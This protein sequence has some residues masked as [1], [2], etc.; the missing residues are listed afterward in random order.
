MLHGGIAVFLL[1]TKVSRKKIHGGTWPLILSLT[2]DTWPNIVM[3]ALELALNFEASL[4]EWCHSYIIMVA[5]VTT[6]LA[7]GVHLSV[8]H[9]GYP[10]ESSW[11]VVMATLL[12]ISI[13]IL[14]ITWLS[15]SVTAVSSTCFV[16]VT[17]R[18]TSDMTVSSH[19]SC[20][21]LTGLVV[22]ALLSIS[23]G[24]VTSQYLP[25]VGAS[26]PFVVMVTLLSISVSLVIWQPLPALAAS[27]SYVAMATLLSVSVAGETWPPLPAVAVSPAVSTGWRY[28]STRAS[29]LAAGWVGMRRRW[30]QTLRPASPWTVVVSSRCQHLHHRKQFKYFKWWSF[31]EV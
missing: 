30:E 31:S 9:F 15:L 2:R 17:L 8:C 13:A 23:I 26:L 16:R 20:M 7:V 27:L 14:I 6:L 18:D 24:V 1:G 28:S 29:S 3:V 25:V 22:A 21:S 12:R 10:V 19:S 4:A 5:V 11:G